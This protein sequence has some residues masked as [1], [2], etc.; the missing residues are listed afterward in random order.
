MLPLS[1]VASQ[2]YHASV[3]AGQ[4]TAPLEFSV[5]MRTEMQKLSEATVTYQE[6]ATN[7]HATA[8]MQPQ[9]VPYTCQ[10]VT[11]GGGDE[12]CETVCK[13]VD[14]P[15]NK[16]MVKLWRR[17]KHSWRVTNP[18]CSPQYCTCHPSSYT[19]EDM[20]KIVQADENKQPSGLPECM[21]QAPEGTTNESNRTFT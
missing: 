5:A 4:V 12:W 9:S 13:G 2:A 19:M 3:Q 16:D 6:V 15:V 8:S 21:W 1:A 14:E 17:G 18:E 11:A 10:A 7:L 20:V